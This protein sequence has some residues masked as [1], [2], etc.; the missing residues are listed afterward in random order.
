MAAKTGRPGPKGQRH[1]LD[2]QLTRFGHLQAQLEHIEKLLKQ[3]VE[4]P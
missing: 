2:I 1:Q 4:Q 3:L